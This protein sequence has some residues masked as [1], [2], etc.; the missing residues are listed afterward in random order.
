[1]NGETVLWQGAPSAAG[2]ARHALH[3]RGLAVY[4]GAIL[5]FSG[6]G[7]IAR[8]EALPEVAHALLW[9]GLLAAAPLVLL[10]AFA[11]LVAR[12]TRYTITDRR[13]TLRF[14]IAIPR[15]LSLP[16][17]RIE[18]ASALLRAAGEGDVAL[19]PERSARLNPL[20][21][22]PHVRPWR[23]RAEPTL[24]AVPD[25]AA[26]AAVL[27]RALARSAAMPAPVR[28]EMPQVAPVRPHAPAAA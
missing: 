8:G 21:L 18:A 5:V 2:L 17:A 7:R 15:T 4:F 22:W 27:A 20:L 25:A 14:G 28:T 6:V 11:L 1:V 10:A 26:A 24:R 23:L 12:T 16:L 9:L 13:V 3:L 19:R